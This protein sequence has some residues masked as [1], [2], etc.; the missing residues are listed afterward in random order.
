MNLCKPLFVRH[1]NNHHK[2]TIY[3]CI[4]TSEVYKEFF[5]EN[6][7]AK[8]DSILSQKTLELC[9]KSYDAVFESKETRK[10]R[11]DLGGHVE[12]KGMI[13]KV[14]FLKRADF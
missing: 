14:R 4:M 3:N 8:V 7:Y 2:I 6:G 1:F 13:S 5:L 10:H 9:R 11:H 12:S